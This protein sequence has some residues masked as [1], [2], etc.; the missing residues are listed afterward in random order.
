MHEGLAQWDIHGELTYL[1]SMHEVVL[2]ISPVPAVG[3]V[4]VIKPHR[5]ICAE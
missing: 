5:H 4:M 1:E 3:L 2:F